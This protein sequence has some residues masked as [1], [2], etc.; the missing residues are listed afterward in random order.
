VPTLKSVFKGGAQPRPY[1]KAAKSKMQIYRGIRAN[2]QAQYNYK[3]NAQS[4]CQE[5]LSSLNDAVNA[6][7]L[8]RGP[9]SQAHRTYRKP[10]LLHPGAQVTV[11]QHD[12]AR[13]A[14]LVQIDSQ[15]EATSKRVMTTEAS[16][17]RSDR[18]KKA[19]KRRPKTR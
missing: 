7:P 5:S 19:E 15:V 4:I 18:F 6:A 1:K 2:S 9:Q 3:S 10:Q 13:E 14:S 17:R 8:Q 11:E 16:A 12:S